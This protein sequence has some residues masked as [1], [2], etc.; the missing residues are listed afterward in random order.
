MTIKRYTTDDCD[1]WDAFVRTSRNGTFLFERSYM[2]YHRDRFVDFSL[3]YLNAK[4]KPIA[5]LSGN[6]VGMSCQDTPAVYSSHSGLTYGGF[7]LSPK[8]KAHEVLSLFDVT[9]QYLK[10]QGFSYWDYKAIPYIYHQMP[11]EEEEYALWL[12]HA[13]LTSC[14]ISTTIDLQ[15]NFALHI[16]TEKQRRH[17]KALREGFSIHETDD[18]SEFWRVV[19]ERLDK[20]YHVRPVHSLAEITLLHNAFPQQ[21]RCFVATL[22]DRIEGG[23][24]I[25]ETQLVAHAQYS[26]ATPFGMERGVMSLLYLHLIDYY[27]SH[28]PDIRFFDFGISTESGG[29]YLNRSLISFKED[30]A[31]RGVAYKCFR[32]EV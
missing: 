19:E 16:D 5:L 18:F 24:V 4:N 12:N 13:T 14:A 22:N 1:E 8:T 23:V 17:N 15:S 31:G 9:R 11:S 27:K 2:D 28:R 25:Y 10:E 7:I 29:L 32:I 3:M 30:F 21:I 26:E 6:A 20:K